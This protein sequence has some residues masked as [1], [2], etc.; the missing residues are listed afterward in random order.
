MAGGQLQ[1]D[2]TGATLTD[3]QGNR[4]K[5]DPKKK[6]FIILKLKKDKSK[7]QETR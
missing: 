3:K 6:L 5:F 2:Q 7:Y 4:K 1:R